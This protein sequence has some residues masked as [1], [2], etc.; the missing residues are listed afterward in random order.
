MPRNCIHGINMQKAVSGF[1]FLS[2]I[3][4]KKRVFFHYWK[5]KEERKCKK[6]KGVLFYISRWRP[7]HTSDFY[8]FG[9]FV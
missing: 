9:I 6:V 7:V 3:V 8:D 1:Y 4:K 2:K 5:K